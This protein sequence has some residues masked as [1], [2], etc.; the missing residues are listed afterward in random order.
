MD[1][2]W[3]RMGFTDPSK[4]WPFGQYTP[5]GDRVD[6]L[7]VCYNTEHRDKVIKALNI[8][9]R[10]ITEGQAVMGSRFSRVIVLDRYW[11]SVADRE[12]FSRWV[13]E[14]LETCLTRDGELHLI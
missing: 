10:Y 9:A 12:H 13:H 5:T 8:P 1:I 7:V 14:C 11:A 3:Q 4:E 2:D 6:T